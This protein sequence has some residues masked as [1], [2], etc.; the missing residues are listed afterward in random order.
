MEKGHSIGQKINLG[1]TSDG[2][3]IFAGRKFNK[4]FT[5]FCE[6]FCEYLSQ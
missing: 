2:Q 4:K 1:Q 3:S 6:T 5:K